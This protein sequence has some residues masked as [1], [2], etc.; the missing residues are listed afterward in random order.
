MLPS[1]VAVVA[2][3]DAE[4][5]ERAQ[6]A[7]ADSLALRERYVAQYGPIEGPVVRQ[8]PD[9][10]RAVASAAG[11]DMLETIAGSPDTVAARL[12]N[13][14][15]LGINHVLVRFMGEWAGATRHISEESMRLFSREV[16]PRFKTS[17]PHLA[18]R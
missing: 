5:L 7:K 1:S 14:V 18:L 12:Q 2:P 3:T 16:M 8:K 17:Q 10:S 6:A 9:E 15:D 4:A 11:G 13:L